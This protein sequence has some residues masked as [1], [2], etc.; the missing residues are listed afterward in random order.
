M[1]NNSGNWN[2][3]NNYLDRLPDFLLA[4][5]VLILG[6]IIAKIIEKAIYKGLQKTKLDDKIFPEGKPKKYSSEKIISKIIFYILL[7]YVFSLFFNILNLTVITSPLVSMLSSIFGA[8][9]NILK[10]AIIL[11]VAWLVAS[12]LKYLIK[13]SGNTLKVHEKL[14]K[15]K[16]LDNNQQQPNLIDKIANIVFYFVLLLFLPAV[17]G[18]LDLYGVSEPFANMLQNILAFLPKLLAAALIVLVGYFA[19]K[20][21]RTIITSFLQSVGLESLANRFGM[22]KLFEK[23]SLSTIVG[24]I[25]FIFIMIPVVISALE[26]L[27][28]DGISQPAVSML[29]DVLTMIPNIAVAI[30]LVLL[31][32]WI[33]KW[34]KQIVSSL[35]SGLGIDSYVH[36]IGIAPSTSIANLIGSIAQILVVFL[37]AV[38]AL[39]LLGLEFLVTLST[40]VV[41]YLPQV[42][43]A[44]VIIGVGL[45][46]GV[47]VKNTLAGLLHGAAFRLLPSIA[48]YSIIAITI[49]MALDQLGVAS[50]IVTA[51]FTLILGG[52]AL[53]FGLAFGLGGKDFAAK[54]LRKLDAKMDESGIN[55]N[56][57][58]SSM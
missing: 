3:W 18:A 2:G 50:S 33:G 55:K 16:L 1:I 54:R 47:L 57:D 36:K 38:Q 7:V 12:G 40:A 20:I 58:D 42:I 9:P 43:A 32:V 37:M 48:K 24:N 44:V 25:V 30:F 15:W 53:A 52:L 29:N 34:I 35:L 5:V 39:N 28:I 27:D 22:A 45:W 13:K 56:Q 41:A 21:V 49:F 6:W 17:L 14:N 10:A 51:A 31:G 8:I 46:L 26:K 19:A 4:V 23:T 11:L